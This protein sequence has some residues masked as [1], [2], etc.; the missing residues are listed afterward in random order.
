MPFPDYKT[1]WNERATT[2]AAAMGAVDGSAD[3]ATLRCNGDYSARQVRTA[4]DLQP[5]DRVFELG[6]GVARIG[7]QLAAD[8]GQWHGLDIAENMLS[9]ARQ[10]MAEFSNVSFTALDAPL[11]PL[12][13]AS[14]DKGYCVAVFIHMDK[15]DFALYLA[16]VA[17]VLRPGGLFYFDNW[18]LANPVGWRRFALELLQV[19]NLPPGQRKDVARNQFCVPEEVLAYTRGA[20]LE[21]IITLADSP[22]VQM[23]VRKPDG[24]KATVVRETERCRSNAASIAY[25]AEWTAYFDAQVDDGFA[26]STPRVLHSR[27]LAAPVDSPVANMF[28]VYLRGLWAGRTSTWGPIPAD[29]QQTDHQQEFSS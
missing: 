28:R 15:E 6:C 18:N 24:D 22:W 25:D 5:G 23:V 9:V 21:P 20:G 19:Q 3:E 11:L 8:C 1:C 7:H 4:L 10:R 17:R 26:G 14:M 13:D 2:A 29:L 27:L 12:A 16:D